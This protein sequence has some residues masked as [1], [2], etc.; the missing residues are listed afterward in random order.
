[1]LFRSDAVRK[2]KFVRDNLF[3]PIREALPG[4]WIK[5]VLGNHEW[6]VQKHMAVATP[7]MLAVLAGLHEW[8][9]ADLFG[10]RELEVDV[11]C[12]WDLAAFTRQAVEA[13]VR[14]NYAV[15]WECF[16]AMHI[17]D[18]RFGLSGTNGHT[19]KPA[20]VTGANVARGRRS[21]W[22]WTTTGSGCRGNAEYVDGL[23]KS[24]QGFAIFHVD[25]KTGI[26]VPENVVIQGDFAAVAGRYWY[27]TEGER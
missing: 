3:R 27:R 26:V 1:M 21:P 4:A 10:V 9:W 18:D 17:R 14:Q 25:T 20:L 11:H 2:L 24:S 5:W 22:S 13:E 12:K 23:D 19:H 6:R 8:E 16:V 15:F 7:H